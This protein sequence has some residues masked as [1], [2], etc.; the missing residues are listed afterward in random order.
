MTRLAA[1]RD[2]SH[3]AAIL[4]DG[5][6]AVVDLD[7]GEVVGTAARRRAPRTWRPWTT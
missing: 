4:A 6:V 3:A 7:A 1:Y 5:T 2:G